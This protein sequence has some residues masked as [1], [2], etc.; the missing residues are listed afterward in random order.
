MPSK[1]ETKLSQKRLGSNKFTL[2]KFLRFYKQTRLF[3]LTIESNFILVFMDC[4][5]NI[6]K[7]LSKRNRS[8]PKETNYM[9]SATNY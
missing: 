7:S 1:L 9:L 5:V 8:I 4:T 3:L 2:S 6:Y